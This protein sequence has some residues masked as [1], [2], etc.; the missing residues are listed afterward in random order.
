MRLSSTNRICFSLPAHLA[1]LPSCAYRRRFASRFLA[2]PV[3]SV[4]SGGNSLRFGCNSVWLGQYSLHHGQGYFE[5]DN[6]LSVTDRVLSGAQRV[7]CEAEGVPSGPQGVPSGAEGLYSGV[8]RVASRAEGVAST[9]KIGASTEK[10][11]VFRPE[12]GPSAADITPSDTN[13]ILCHRQ[14][15]LGTGLTPKAIL[16]DGTNLDLSGAASSQNQKTTQKKC[17]YASISGLL[18]RPITH[19]KKQPVR[20]QIIYTANRP[21]RPRPSPSRIYRRG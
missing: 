13:S 19:S 4:R 20:Y 17:N 11:T 12:A 1:S 2:H 5:T 21:I 10:T 9:E 15:L 3:S 7:L 18:T 16:S 14:K 8:E 6:T